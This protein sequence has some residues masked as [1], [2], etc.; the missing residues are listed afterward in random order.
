MDASSSTEAALQT[1]SRAELLEGFKLPPSEFAPISFYFWNGEPLTRERLSW[2]LEQLRAQGILG[3]VVSYIHRPD[4]TID[5][6]DPPVFSEAWWSLFKWFLKES[7]RLGM[8][9]GVQD[10]CIV[11]PALEALA[12]EDPALRGAELRQVHGRVSTGQT[13]HLELPED[14]AA[15]ISVRA[16]PSVGAGLRLEGSL[17]LRDALRDRHLEW[18]AVPGDW[19]VVIVYTVSKGFNPLHITSGARA[20]EVLYA[21]F[22]MHC[23]EEIGKTLA[24]FFQDELDFGNSMP[25]WS[26]EIPLE[27]K[28]RHGYDLEPELAALWFD[29]EG[30]DLGSRT[31]KLR[32]DYADVVTRLTEA[33]YF[34]PVFAWHESHGTLLGHDNLGRGDIAEGRR[35]YGDAFRTMRWFSAPGCDDPHLQGPRRFQGFKVNSSI[36]HLYERERVWNE[37]FYGS[38][39][40]VTPAQLLA[41]LNEDFVYGATLFNPHALYYTTLGGWWEWASPDFHFRQPYWSLSGALWQY[42]TRLSFL[43][44]QGRHRC[45]VAVLYPITDL[46]AGFEGAEGVAASFARRAMDE[47][48]DFDFLDFESLERAVFSDGQLQVAGE[49]YRALVFPAVHTVRHSSLVK[50]LEFKRAGGVVIALEFAPTSSERLG[51]ED[52]ELEVMVAAL[53]GTS[54]VVTDDRAAL[55]ALNRSLE[56]DFLCNSPDV[57]VLHRVIGGLGAYFV[58][59]R[60]DEGRRVTAR[61]RAHGHPERW[62]AWT[63]DVT[64]LHAARLEGPY[65]HLEL[66]FEP[67]EA[68]LIVFSSDAPPAPSLQPDAAAHTT[69]EFPALWTTE[70]VPM[71]DNRHGDFRHPPEPRLVEPELRRFRHAEE[72]ELQPAWAAPDLDD[73]DWNDVLSGYGPRFWKLGPVPRKVDLEHLEADLRNLERIEPAQT[74]EVGGVR[75][76]WS[77][78]AFSERFG[79]R[80]DPL[81][82]H[83]LTGPHGLKGRVP[84]EFIDLGDPNPEAAGCPVYLWTSVHSA[85]AGSVQISAGSRAAYRVWL[86][87]QPVVSQEVS[88]GVGRHEPW[89]IPDYSAPTR[90]GIARTRAGHNRLLM[91][92]TLEGTQRTRAFVAL[93]S[94]EGDP[95]V[96]AAPELRWFRHGSALHFDHRPTDPP[97]AAWLRYLAPPGTR[98][99]WV[100]AHGSLHGWLGGQAL[101]A[102]PLGRTASGA[103]RYQL[104][105]TTDHPE[106]SLLALRIEPDAG[107]AGGA[108]LEEPIR[109][110][111]GVGKAAVGDWSRLGLR[112]YSGAVRYRTTIHLET[113]HLELLSAGT[114][115]ELQLGQVVA[116]AQVTVNG[117]AAG[118]CLSAPWQL[119][120]TALLRE[121]ANEFEIL[122]TNTLA[123]HLEDTPTPYVLEGQTSA[124][125]YG[126]VRLILITSDTAPSAN[127]V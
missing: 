71:L 54:G 117:R 27:F 45:D 1:P 25:R 72:T 64:P 34:K 35:A 91:R 4:G 79:I 8:Q 38:G 84:D 96:T 100:S 66:T 47:G 63:G 87:G 76:P 92:L 23:P 70:I 119:D 55:E 110:E 83:W 59:N 15:A 73:T 115:A 57:C 49:S 104:E 69:L 62:D 112:G 36:A 107:Y 9:V 74:L 126:S 43:L 48:L 95:E 13:L 85:Q 56:R 33:H 80:N 60:S 94:S 67:R 5:P 11:N 75:L 99:L 50:A 120:V 32:V 121:G 44:S 19:C 109:L 118:I 81:L 86:E 31:V 51:H 125:L 124:G 77:E 122:V 10:Y 30:F 22:E 7:E 20:I 123:N 58:F 16:Y 39:W 24:V 21:P 105:V 88:L 26:P 68:Q 46:E 37:G 89:G 111:C 82:G 65:Q 18:L 98:R 90:R 102:T 41:A 108:V 114:R 52:P 106:A 127:I 14:A 42:V 97:R 101:D 78:Y 61:F 53:F 6:G 3:T 28:R 40:G 116:A 17:D 113:L 2:Q 103:R 29:L 93:G 12:T